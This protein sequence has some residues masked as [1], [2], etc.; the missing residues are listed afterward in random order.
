MA[1]DGWASQFE[2]PPEWRPN[3]EI[4]NNFL[5][6]DGHLLKPSNKKASAISIDI[7]HIRIYWSNINEISLISIEWPYEAEPYIKK[8]FQ[9]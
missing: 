1:F 4:K 2:N 5:Y 9:D 7:A 6:L 8:I 3:I